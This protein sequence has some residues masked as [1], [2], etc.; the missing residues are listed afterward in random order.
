M[1]V[2]GMNSPRRDN[3]WLSARPMQGAR[4]VPEETPLFS[5]KRGYSTAEDYSFLLRPASLS[6]SAGPHRWTKT[7]TQCGR[8]H[9]RKGTTC[10]VA[11]GKVA[12]PDCRFAYSSRE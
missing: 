2:M 10:P 9:E 12:R 7:Q 11:P 8:S 5:N 1:R 3:C 4:T 6:N